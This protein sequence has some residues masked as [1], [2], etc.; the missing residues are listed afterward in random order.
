MRGV[1]KPTIR[2]F[3]LNPKSAP[4]D[5]IVMVGRLAPQ[6]TRVKTH[7][8]SWHFERGAWGG[9]MRKVNSLAS[10]PYPQKS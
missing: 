9:T 1:N 6:S 8:L 7:K 5:V 3:T 10:S 4:S 2:Q